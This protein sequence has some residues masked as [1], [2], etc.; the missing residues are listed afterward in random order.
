MESAGHLFIRLVGI[1]V[2]MVLGHSF[3]FAQSEY[4]DRYIRVIVPLSPG[5]GGDLSFGPFKDRVGNILGQPLVVSYRPGSSGA[6]GTASVAKSKPDG[7]TLLLANKGGLISTPLTMKDAGYTMA[8]LTPICL[9]TRSPSI[10]YVQ[11]Q[12]PYK[13]LADF[14]EAA[15]TKKLS[16][17]TYGALSLSHLAMKL[18]EKHAG[19][20]AIHVPYGGAGEANIALLGGHVDMAIGTSAVKLVGPG[21]LRAVALS[22]DKRWELYPNVPTMKELG[23]PV[24]KGDPFGAMFSLWAP[25]GTPK[26]IVDKIYRAFKKVLDESGK[27]IAKGLESAELNLEFLG[28]DEFAEVANEEYSLV[29]KMIEEMGVRPQ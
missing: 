16:Y 12:S 2:L 15:K 6:I 24:L 27:E 10:F 25:K 5:G 26:E 11:D 22:A 7:Y 29:K 14:I 23:F 19:F 1:C 18:V 20:E 28:P 3:A 21:K 4:P 8:D 13:S 9:L 17:A